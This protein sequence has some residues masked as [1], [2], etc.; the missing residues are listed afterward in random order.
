MLTEDDQCEQMAS[1]SEDTAVF[2]SLQ[3]EGANVAALI[4]SSANYAPA[5]LYNT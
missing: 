3:L 2:P 5:N 1:F 4:T